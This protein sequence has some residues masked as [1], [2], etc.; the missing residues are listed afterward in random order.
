[1]ASIL[2]A[3]MEIWKGEAYVS[4]PWSGKRNIFLTGIIPFKIH[5]NLIF[6]T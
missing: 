5:K 3:S 1:M 6:I 4:L 2:A